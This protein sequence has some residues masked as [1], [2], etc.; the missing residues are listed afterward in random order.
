MG[1]PDRSGPTLATVSVWFAIGFPGMTLP[2]KFPRVFWL[3]CLWPLLFPDG[4][5]GQRGLSTAVELVDP[6]A[7]RKGVN[8][9][10]FF[11]VAVGA[12][13]WDSSWKLQ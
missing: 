4:S 11:G 13:R 8:R 6:L 1:F 12:V 10:G 5:V 2:V 9:I 3:F 7:G